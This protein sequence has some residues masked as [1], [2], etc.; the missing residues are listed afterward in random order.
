METQVVLALTENNLKNSI[1]FSLLR[2]KFKISKV[3]NIDEFEQT[4]ELSTAQ[5]IIVIFNEFFSGKTANDMEAY[6]KGFSGNIH[7][8]FLGNYT[9]E[10]DLAK[11]CKHKCFSYLKKPFSHHTLISHIKNLFEK[12]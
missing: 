5:K 2:L 4:I 3:S 12:K 9:R 6:C 11:H 10:T 7:W 8:V 1:A